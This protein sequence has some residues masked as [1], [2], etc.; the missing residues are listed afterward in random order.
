[1]YLGVISCDPVEYRTVCAVGVTALLPRLLVLR[2]FISVTDTLRSK[3]VGVTKRLVYAFEIL[4]GHENLQIVSNSSLFVGISAHTRSKAVEQALGWV[5]Q[6]IGFCDCIVLYL[7]VMLDEEP[8]FQG[9]HKYSK[10]KVSE[11]Q[12][13]LKLDAQMLQPSRAST[14]L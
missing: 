8:V 4:A 5:A 7:D 3:V 13:Y 2:A 12:V 1:M 11:V 6:N 10:L 9:S 14:I